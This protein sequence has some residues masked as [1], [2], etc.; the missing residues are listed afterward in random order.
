[1]I[2][3]YVLSYTSGDWEKYAAEI[4]EAHGEMENF[5]AS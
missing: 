4:Q 5:T 3:F 1:M 2:Y